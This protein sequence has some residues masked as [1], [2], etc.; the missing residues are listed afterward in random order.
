M[1]QKIISSSLTVSLSVEVDFR[2]MPP[3]LIGFKVGP[4]L[5]KS[6]PGGTRLPGRFLKTALLAWYM[7]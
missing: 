5:L 4:E 7:L 6:P 3:M 2:R 1:N